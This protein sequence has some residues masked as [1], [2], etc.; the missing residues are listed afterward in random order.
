MKKVFFLTIISLFLVTPSIVFAE[1]EYCADENLRD[2]R[3]ELG[4]IDYEYVIDYEDI[5]NHNKGGYHVDYIDIS[6]T[7]LPN[8]YFAIVEDGD[9]SYEIS[10]NP[11][12]VSGG[13]KRIYFYS[14]ECSNEP[15]KKEEIF[16]PYYNKGDMKP[17][18]DGSSA[19]TVSNNN[20]IITVTLS[21]VTIIL[22][23]VTILVLKKGRKI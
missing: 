23:V 9:R 15:L 11:A 18:S 3:Q 14:I 4:T 8:D 10:A 21:V 6:V 17:F 13:V 7:G 1:G 16:L 2:Y 20:V 22:F 5:K 12:K 19:E